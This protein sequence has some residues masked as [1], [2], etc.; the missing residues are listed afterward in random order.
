MFGKIHLITAATTPHCA[1]AC[2]R[3]VPLKAGGGSKLMFTLQSGAN[4]ERCV[5]EVA[6]FAGILCGGPAK[7]N[8]KGVNKKNGLYP[9]LRLN[10][11]KKSNLATVGSNE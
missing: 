8:V 10:A 1:Q 2:I 5:F 11:A 6:N 4:V 3:V 9:F 7:N